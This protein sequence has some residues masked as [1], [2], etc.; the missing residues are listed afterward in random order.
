M[1]FS[2]YFVDQLFPLLLDIQA[3]VKLIV[4]PYAFNLVSN[5]LA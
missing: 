2:K 3:K 4:F 1:R 5:T